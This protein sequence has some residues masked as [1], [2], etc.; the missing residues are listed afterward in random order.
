[1]NTLTLRLPVLVMLLLCIVATAS[2][3]S[4]AQSS[5]ASSISFQGALTG[6]NGQTL[7]NGSYNLG[8]KFYTNA[9][10]TNAL[11]TTNVTGVLVTGGIASTTIPVEAAWFD[12]QTRY[13]GISVNGGVELEPRVLVTAVPYAISASALETNVVIGTNGFV[14]IG[15]GN[16]AARLEVRGE[17]VSGRVSILS[18]GQCLRVD[19]DFQNLTET[20]TAR[21]A[22]HDPFWGVFDMGLAINY[23]NP[24]GPANTFDILRAFKEGSVLFA[25]DGEG[26][27]RTRVLQITGGADLAEHLSVADDHPTDEYRVKP[28]MAVSIDPSGNRKFKISD[29]PYDRKRVGIISGGNGVKPG[30]ILGDEGNPAV[31]GDQPIALTGQVWCHADAT[32]GPIVPGDLLTTSSTPGHAMKVSDDAKARFAVLGQA[33]TGLK[34]GRGW[35]QVLVGKQ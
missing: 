27:T 26:K 15:T 28:G 33:L 7:P 6:T 31:A 1:M 5:G 8:F 14:G 12:G 3:R 9:L 25:V 23:R 10:T 13:F 21:F 20:E 32:F 19:S 18:G 24:G 2:N 30:L 22:A 4:Q 16:P 34:K 29:E 35:V 11:A 17:V